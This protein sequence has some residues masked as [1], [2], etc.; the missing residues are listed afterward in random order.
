MHGNDQR[1]RRGLRV[2]RRSP[3]RFLICPR[4][5]VAQIEQVVGGGRGYEIV[6]KLGDA[7]SLV[8][9]L[10]PRQRTKGGQ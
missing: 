10:D 5:D 4:H 7:A 2:L 1:R 6:E 8:A 3:A 9:D